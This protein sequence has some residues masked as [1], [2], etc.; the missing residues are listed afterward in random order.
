MVLPFAPCT[1]PVT[2]RVTVGPS[3]GGAA[4]AADGV[5][6]AIRA[7]DNSST[8]PMPTDFVTRI[9]GFRASVRMVSLFMI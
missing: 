8:I 6:I 7:A 1:K 9:A 4:L 5:I 3:H 2:S